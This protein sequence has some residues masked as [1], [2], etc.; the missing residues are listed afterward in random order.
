ML[1]VVNEW[2]LSCEH[3]LTADCN[4]QA[5]IGQAAC[6][7]ALGVPEDITREAWHMLTQSQQDEANRKADEAILVWEEH[8]DACLELWRISNS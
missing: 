4:R 8:Q 7:L 2:P 5:W 1:R 6:C 3:N